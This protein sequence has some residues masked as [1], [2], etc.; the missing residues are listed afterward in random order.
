VIWR[1]KE[2]GGSVALLDGE[3][4]AK[5]DTFER[6][7]RECNDASVKLMIHFMQFDLAQAWSTPREGGPRS[8]GIGGVGADSKRASGALAKQALETALQLARLKALPAEAVVIDSERGSPKQLQ[9]V[10]FEGGMFR[11]ACA[12]PIARF[13]RRIQDPEHVGYTYLVAPEDLGKYLERFEQ[14]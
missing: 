8:A 11:V 12:D 5:P 10:S 14:A 3:R 2:G 6:V 7:Y 1:G 4:P 13:G 9:I